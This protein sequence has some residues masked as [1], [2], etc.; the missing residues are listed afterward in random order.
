MLG[1]RPYT[2]DRVFR[3]GISI[4]IG[5]GAI[6]VV[7][8]LSD[9]L[10]PFVVAFLLAYLLNPAVT[11]LERKIRS[12]ALAVFGVLASSLLI[13]TLA[14]GLLTP[15]VTAEIRHLSTL[16]KKVVTDGEIAQRADKNLPANV[17]DTLREYVQTDQL[18]FILQQPDAWSLGQAVFKKVVPGLWGLVAG[19]TNFLLGFI[20]LFVIGLYLV[21][22]LMDFKR[23]KNEWKSLVPPEW[24]KP[25]F[26][27]ISEVDDGMN[28]YFRAQAVVASTVGVLF[29]IGFTII[30]LPMGIL[31][32]LFIGLLN[33]VPYL[34]IA[35]FIP[36]AIL[37][38]IM[39]LESG[40]SVITSL[41]LV[42]A[43]FAIVQLIQDSFITPRI[44]GKVTGLSPA[45]ILLSISIWGKLLG[46]MGLIIALPATCMV[47]AYYRRMLAKPS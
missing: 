45:M 23:S 29:A 30:D 14:I 28:R 44:M 16:G 38:I 24:Q 27:F 26:D 40:G 20:G 25:V 35:G 2:F 17:W 4:A 43:V 11:R 31:L 5:Y 10:L 7:Q 13:L 9:V 19:T 47:L 39:A 34:Q 41:A 42:G 1:E 15:L 32:G 18:K 36:A 6:R 37:A 12:R 21:F 22:L 46:F 8:H 3:L 33:M